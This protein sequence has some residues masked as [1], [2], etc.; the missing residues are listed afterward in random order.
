MQCIIKKILLLH[1]PYK[2]DSRRAITEDTFID[3]DQDDQDLMFDNNEEIYIASITIR[4]K[5]IRILKLT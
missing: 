1:T 2:I 3:G 4:R 5:N